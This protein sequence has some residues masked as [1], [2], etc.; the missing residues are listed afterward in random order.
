M[1]GQ[2]PWLPLTSIQELPQAVLFDLDG[3]LVDTADDLG[4]AL[5]H[6]LTLHGLPT[7]TAEAYRPMASHGAKGLLQLGFGEAL[8]DY[9]FAVL[10]QQLLAY[11]QQHL[12]H[13]SKLF[14]GG[15]ALLQLL[16]SVDI[17]WG[18]VT[19]KPYKLSAQMLREMPELSR[20]KILLAGDSLSQRKPNPIPLLVA[21]H[22]L[23]VTRNRCW[24]IGDA[25]R[26]IEAGNRANM[27]TF[28]AGFGFIDKTD[29]PETWGA[30]Y[31]LDS[32]AELSAVVSAL[33]AKKA[34]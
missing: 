33:I 7:K 1:N 32:F 9:D 25:E 12:T 21:S 28:I 6:V 20:C 30:D 26:D 18:I 8:V 14:S 10:R 27:K 4:A 13:H 31:M 24:Y 2:S 29:T 16:D 15:Y 5:N 23:K 19:N 17:P 34:Q 11:Y 22:Q 3:T